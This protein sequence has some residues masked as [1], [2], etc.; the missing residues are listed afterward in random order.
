MDFCRNEVAQC[1]LGPQME[2]AGYASPTH[3]AL[4]VQ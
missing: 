3:S 4:L 1:N 2:A